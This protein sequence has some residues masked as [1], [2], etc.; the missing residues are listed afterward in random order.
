M[1]NQTFVT[2]ML[3]V[4][5]IMA[6][7]YVSVTVDM[8]AMVLFVHLLGSVHQTLIVA[9]MKGVLTMKLALYILVLVWMVIKSMKTNAKDHH[10]RYIN[11]I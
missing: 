5:Y 11:N 1:K 4:R 6:I 8:K 7:Q 9:Q 2:C 10:V 3:A